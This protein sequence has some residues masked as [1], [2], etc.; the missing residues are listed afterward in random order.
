MAFLCLW[1]DYSLLL[2]L[3]PV[4]IICIARSRLRAILDLQPDGQILDPVEGWRMGTPSQSVPRIFVSHSHEDDAFCLRLIGDLRARLGEDAVWYDTSGGLH[5]GDDW[6]DR[7]VQ[8]I[9]ARPLFLVVL[10]PHADASKWV[11]QEMGIAFRQHVESGK[12]LLP[13]RIA[14]SPRRADWAAIHEFD[15][16]AYIQPERYAAALTDLLGVFGA[17]SNAPNFLFSSAA[18]VGSAPVTV[19]S[20]TGP[21]TTGRPQEQATAAAATHEKHPALGPSRESFPERL[22][23]LGFMYRYLHDPDTGRLALVVLPPLCPVPA[24][25]FL[26][27]SDPKQDGQAYDDEKPQ[28]TMDL[29]A[30]QIGR[31]PVTVAEYACFVEAGHMWPTTDARGMTWR[32]QLTR[33]DH[34]VTCVSW[35]ETRDYTRWL[36][37]LTGQP[38][39]L[40]SEA[41][42]EKAARWDD[43]GNGGRGLARI[44][45]WG[46][47]FEAAR[48]NTIESSNKTTTAVGTYGPEN[49]AH[50]GSSPCGAQDMAGNV[51][52]WTRT[53]YDAQAY[54]KAV[55]RDDANSPS[56]RVLRGG[57]WDNYARD[58]RVTCRHSGSLVY[59][60]GYLLPYRGF[61]LAL[62]AAAGW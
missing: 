34:P 46:D 12:Q 56:D 25:P 5:G 33:L 15:F 19:S 4:D 62:R 30:Y 9:T 24:G 11:Q 29:P 3:L 6:W 49:P 59:D 32:M 22:Q 36:A 23:H 16:Q 37:K 39:D 18:P 8:E 43:M 45:P 17:E 58:A 7:I 54:A 51:W 38:W 20:E 42:W 2:N 28:I 41:E 26:M 27:G 57:S 31:F 48:C 21:P 55:S 14:P 47:C 40:P 50:D 44:Y 35:Q 61:R 1:P 60:G 52:E 10:S 53:I 13:V